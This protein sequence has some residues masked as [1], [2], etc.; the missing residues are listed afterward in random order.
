MHYLCVS[1]VII[2]IIVKFF[3]ICILRMYI[4]NCFWFIYFVCNSAESVF[5]MSGGIKR[6]HICIHNIIYTYREYSYLFVFMHI[7]EHECIAYI[8]LLSFTIALIIKCIH[9]HLYMHI[10]M[11]LYIGTRSYQQTVGIRTSINQK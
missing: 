10:E 9:I 5:N 4:D 7:Y 1:K 2:S 11:Y 6:F 3:G 8:F